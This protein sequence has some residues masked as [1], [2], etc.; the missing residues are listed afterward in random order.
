MMRDV[1]MRDTVGTPAE[2]AGRRVLA[3]PRSAAFGGSGLPGQA[4]EIGVINGLCLCGCRSCKEKSSQLQ[5]ILIPSD[6]LTHVFTAR[7]ITALID[8]IVDEILERVRQ[9]DVHCRHVGRIMFLAKFGKLASMTKARPLGR[10]RSWKD[11]T[12]LAP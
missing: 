1:T 4:L 3:S 6:Q 2:R 11:L 12:K 5:T 7:A 8:L 9:G 10:S